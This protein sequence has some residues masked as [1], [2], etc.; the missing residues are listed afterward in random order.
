MLA[1]IEDV[2]K[3]IYFANPISRAILGAIGNSSLPLSQVVAKTGISREEVA[4]WLLD[5]KV[6]GLLSDSIELPVSSKEEASFVLEP[7]VHQLLN[8]LYHE[9]AQNGTTKSRHSIRHLWLEVAALLASGAAA[10]V[11]G[12]VAAVYKNTPLAIAMVPPVLAALF[13]GWLLAGSAILDKIRRP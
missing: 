10:L 2:A 13:G 7:K 11:I 5:M 9:F 4:S 1:E 6:K 12:V 3:A 8:Q